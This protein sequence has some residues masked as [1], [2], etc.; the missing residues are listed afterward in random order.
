MKP[1]KKYFPETTG[2]TQE[3]IDWFNKRTTNHISLVQ[4][5]ISKIISIHTFSEQG[6]N[7][8]NHESNIHDETKFKEPEY[9]PYV[10]LS[11]QHKD[12]N[13]K[14]YKKPGT[15]DNK[16]INDATLFHIKNN[17]HHPEYWT[18]Q[19]KNLVNKDDRNKPSPVIINATKM[20]LIYVV[21]MIAD[22]M[23]MSEELKSS[24]YEWLKQNIGVRWKFNKNQVA[25][26]YKILDSCWGK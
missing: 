21:V 2:I 23:A 12:D 4:K 17:K 8:L 13:Y 19:E 24:P 9:T 10:K 26:I 14:S 25:L 5:Y 1:Y 16:E 20:P 11:W 18:D 22:W 15:L 3:M 6:I 7:I